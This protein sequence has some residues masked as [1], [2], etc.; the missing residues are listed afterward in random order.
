MSAL[1]YPALA[2]LLFGAS[3]QAAPQTVHMGNWTVGAADAKSCQAMAPFGD[4]LVLGFTEDAAGAGILMLGDD[5]WKFDTGVPNPGAISFDG[6]TSLPLDFTPVQSD[7][8]TWLL[9]AP[10]GPWFT[11]S[12]AV[13]KRLWVRITTVKFEQGFGIDETTDVLNALVACNANH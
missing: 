2:A 9:V 8:G 3:A 6:K 12:L 11:K 7:D 5:R 4:H 1:R 13:S 10:T